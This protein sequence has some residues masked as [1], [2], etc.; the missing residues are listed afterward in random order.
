M[1]TTSSA[2]ASGRDHDVPSGEVV[3]KNKMCLVMLTRRDGTPMDASSVTEEEIIEICITMGHIH[4]LGV[5]HYSTMESV[6]LFRLTDELQCATCKKNRE[7]NG[8]TG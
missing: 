8:I 3:F 1:S 6:V 5:L 7:S 4:P 2:T